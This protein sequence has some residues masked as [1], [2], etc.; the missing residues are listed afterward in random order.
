[1]KLL[2]FATDRHADNLLLAM[3]RTTIPTP[4]GV[5]TTSEVVTLVLC[6]RGRAN[7]K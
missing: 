4:M 5:L 3:D 2:L 1:M 6:A 7:V